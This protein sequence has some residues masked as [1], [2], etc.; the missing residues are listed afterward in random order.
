MNP[1][2]SIEGPGRR[3]SISHEIESDVEFTDIDEV[4]EDIDTFKSQPFSLHFESMNNTAA[5]VDKFTSNYKDAFTDEALA[6]KYLGAG[7]AE[8]ERILLEFKNTHHLTKE[9]VSAEIR[10]AINHLATSADPED[11]KLK[12]RGDKHFKKN[13]FT[14]Q[15]SNEFSKL[16]NVTHGIIPKNAVTTSTYIVAGLLFALAG[17]CVATGIVGA[18]FDGGISLAIGLSFAAVLSGFALAHL[19]IDW[20]ESAPERQERQGAIQQFEANIR[21]LKAADGKAKVLEEKIKQEEANYTNDLPNMTPEQ[22]ADRKK[23]IDGYKSKLGALKTQIADLASKNSLVD[24]V[25][26]EGDDAASKDL[27]KARGARDKEISKL[28]GKLT[29]LEKDLGVANP[30]A[31]SPADSGS[32]MDDH[33]SAAPIANTAQLFYAVKDANPPLEPKE[34][35][36]IKAFENSLQYSEG[37]GPSTSS[38]P[39]LPKKEVDD[40][41]EKQGGMIELVK[42]IRES[43]KNQ[44]SSEFTMLDYTAQDSQVTPAVWIS[45]LNVWLNPTRLDGL[46]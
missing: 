7:K 6:I 13:F 44:E 21:T 40:F 46:D 33:G 4:R 3:G 34:V 32:T 19:G 37:S 29:K 12:E 14:W 2:S 25:A 28:D 11:V 31:I 30:P 38:H 42:K 41:I 1:A 24:E 23:E 15:G 9:E 16:Y 10:S 39:S 20:M 22:V 5:T 36:A 8:R 26:A 17:V 18:G 27:M 43:A 45:N 35:S